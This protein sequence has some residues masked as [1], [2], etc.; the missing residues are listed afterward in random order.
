[1][2]HIDKYGTGVQRRAVK[3]ALLYYAGTCMPVTMY[4]K[5]SNIFED[6]FCFL[7]CQVLL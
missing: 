7:M 4:P 6:V 1:M 5:T 2:I 3:M